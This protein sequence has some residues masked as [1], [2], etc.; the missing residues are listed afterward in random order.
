MA[1]LEVVPFSDEHLEDAAGLLAA[2][3]ARHRKTEPLLPLRFEAA[4]AAQEELADAWRAEGSSGAAAFR[5]GRQV[6]YLIGAP[7][8]PGDWG[9]NIWVET[10]GHA[11]EDAEEIRDLY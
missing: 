9:E 1:R 5:D 7:R 10:A 6:G 11:V 8:D 3:H 2:R 4:E